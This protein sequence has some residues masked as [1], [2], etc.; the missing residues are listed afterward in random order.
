[1][2]KLLFTVPTLLIALASVLPVQA[3][4]IK[5]DAQAGSHK[6]ALCVGCHGIKGFHTAFPATYRVP[7]LS[8]QGAGYLSAALHAYKSGERKHPSMRTLAASL[9]EQDIAD[10]SAYYESTG[11]GATLAPGAEP[12][13]AKVAELVTKGACAS[14]HGE[15]FSKPISPAYPR[16]AGQHSDYLMAALRSY[17]TT[18]KPFIGRSNAIMGGVAKQFS[19]ADLKLLADYMGSLPGELQTVQPVRFK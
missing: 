19:L 15:N 12:G 6:N 5:G 18:D 3:Q 1:M 17:Q 14:C 16:I 10:L 9:S 4:D 13:P 11:T 2:K 8:G 7:K